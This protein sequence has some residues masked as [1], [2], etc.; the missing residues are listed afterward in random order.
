M[1]NRK[2]ALL[3]S[4]IGFFSAS[5]AAQPVNTLQ[6]AVKKAIVS[7]PDVQA[8]WHTFLSS[9]SEQEV[10]RGGYFPRVDLNAGVGRESLSQPSLPTTDLTRRGATLSLNQMLYDGFATRDEVTRLAHA[11]LVRYFEL[12][13][14]SESTALEASRAYM[15][16]LRYRE[17]SGL[18]QENLTQHEQVFNQIQQRVQAGVGRRVDLEQAGGRLA[19]AQSNVLTEYSNL[20]DVTARYQRIVGEL[21]SDEMAAPELLQQGI[22]PSVEEALNLAFQDSPAFN[23]AIQNVRAA[24]AEAHGRQANFLPR[25]DLRASQEIAYNSS[26][27]AGRRDD[28]IVEVVLNYNLFKGG[29]DRALVRQYAERLELTKDLRDKACREI[30]QTVAIAFDDIQNLSLQLGFLDQHQLAIEKARE[31]Y[32]KQYD[33]GQRSLLDLLDTEN[34]YFQSRRAYVNA[35]YDYAIA[36]ARTLGGMGKLMSA[37]QVGRDGMPTAQELGHDRQ[38]VNVANQCPAEAPLVKTSMA[39]LTPHKTDTGAAKAMVPAPVAPPP[40]TIQQ[41]VAGWAAAWSAKDFPLYR[42]YYAKRFAPEDGVSMAKW[43]SERAVRLGKPG[44]I[45]V[46]ISDLK[47]N[48]SDANKAITDFSQTYTSANYRDEVGKHMEWVREGDHWKIQREQVLSTK[49]AS[50]PNLVKPRTKKSGKRV[51]E[52]ASNCKCD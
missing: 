52:P 35:S 18:A 9:Q 19:L 8:R 45:T 24:E 25:V 28:Q 49:N 47:V 39:A 38:E 37:L 41:A 27:V 36:Y 40:E 44:N 2:I 16:V 6:E 1:S 21:P 17:L 42:G 50:V 5:V 22:P 43:S 15:D 23:A 31:A 51:K 13:D 26:G 14:A 48:T 30:R 33:I 32:R 29:S 10:A 3:V 4:F 20:H 11:K 34:E 46:G 12:L 7:N